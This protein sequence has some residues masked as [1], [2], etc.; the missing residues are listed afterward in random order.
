[1][2]VSITTLVVYGLALFRL[3]RFVTTDKVSQAARLWLRKVGY[4]TTGDRL[5]V[6]N[7]L[8]AWL[9]RLVS[10]NWC[11]SVWIA[12]P[13]VLLAV[14]ENSWWSWVCF[15]LS[16]TTVTGFLGERTSG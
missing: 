10:C 8:A 1:M 16:L 15:A 6:L 9:F 4:R 2:K 13:V 14:Y 12:G 7:R 5:V 11:V 3:T